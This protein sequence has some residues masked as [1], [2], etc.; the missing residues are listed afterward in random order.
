MFMA[1]RNTRKAA[2]EKGIDRMPGAMLR[3]FQTF[4]C[5]HAMFASQVWSTKFLL[6]DNVMKCP[7]QARLLSFLKQLLK[8]GRTAPGEAVLSETCQLPFQYYWL[9]GCLTFWN[10]CLSSGNP[11]LLRV[12]SSDAVLS[13]SVGGC[14]CTQV[15][16]ALGVLTGQNTGTGM[17]VVRNVNGCRPVL[18]TIDKLLE[19]WRSAWIAKS[20]LGLSDPRDANTENR[21]RATYA[22]YFRCGDNT[23]MQGLQYL[24]SYLS[25]GSNL[26]PALLK[27][28]SNFRLGTHNLRVELGRHQRLPYDQRTCLRCGA[29]CRLIDNEHHFLFECD[30]TQNLREDAR[31]HHL[32]P[33]L[34]VREFFS[35]PQTYDVI[36]FVHEGTLLIEPDP[37]L[38]LGAN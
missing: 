4:I 26:K 18:V 32:F 27:S 15:M 35:K 38:I 33:C 2:F 7:L 37:E 5:P 12:C 1:L 17:T 10:A 36:N 21:K 31:F 3:L 19:D 11:L 13:S 20:W 30:S 29:G 8:V 16:K 23:D 34:S 6:L 28:M 24:P 22:A 14:W 25:A 9:K